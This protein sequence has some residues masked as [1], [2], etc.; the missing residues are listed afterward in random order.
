MLHW[1]AGA[2]GRGALLSAD[3][4]TVVPDQEW[5]SFMYSYPN[6][7]SLPPAEVRAVAATVEP[8]PFDRIYGAWWNRVIPTGGKEAVRRSADR[9]VEVVEGRGS[10]RF[11]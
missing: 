5:V 7:I 6:L 11:R 4:I 1:A 9:Y 8:F 3:I 2:E 10:R